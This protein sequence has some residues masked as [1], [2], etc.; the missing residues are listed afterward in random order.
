MRNRLLLTA[1]VVSGL[2]ACGNGTDKTSPT[3]ADISRTQATPRQVTSPAQT[4]PPVA[5]KPE[6]KSVARHAA[7]G[8]YYK[9]AKALDV[10]SGKAPAVV[11]VPDVGERRRALAEAANL[12]EVGVGA[13]VVNGLRSRTTGPGGFQTAVREALAAVKK[14]QALS[15]VDQH[16]IGI[17]GEGLGAHVGAVAVG[18]RPDGVTAAVL[19]GIG[20][21]PLPSKE[22]EPERWLKRATGIQLLFQRDN[23]K[24]S[25]TSAE[26]TRLM[27]ASPPGAL[28][29]QYK[30]LGDAAQRARDIWIKNM[31]IAG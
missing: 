28:M 24:W 2:T 11:L 22:F 30:G 25:M 12:A 4:S 1:C 21:A 3:S 20:D 14:L 7:K 10:P 9:P 16:R 27:I 15:G 17:V 19:A 26:I 23:T 31:L 18:E 8:T 5:V 29:Q 13:L 6:T